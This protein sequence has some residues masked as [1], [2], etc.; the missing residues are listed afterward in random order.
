MTTDVDTLGT[1]Y[2]I[3][4]LMH[5]DSGAFS[6]N[7]R[8]TIQALNGAQLLPAHQKYFLTDIDVQE[9]RKYYNCV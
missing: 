5:F 4:S 1:P 8:P 6:F 7:S 9:I 3:F 2:D